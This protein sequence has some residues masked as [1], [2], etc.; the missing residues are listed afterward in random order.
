MPT[1]SSPIACD[2]RPY[3]FHNQ[4][5]TNPSHGQSPRVDLAVKSK[6]EDLVLDGISYGRR[7][8]V[9]AVEAKRLPTIGAGREREYLHGS[10]SKKGSPEQPAQAN[11]GNEKGGL[12]RFKRGKHGPGLKTVGMIGYVQRHSFDHWRK[13]IHQWLDELIAAPVN[14]LK[15][16]ETDRLQEER[17]SERLAWLRSST[18]R[19]TDNQ[20][21]TVRHLWVELG[22]SSAG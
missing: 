10:P 13:T 7:E 5:M 18:W 22:A 4:H 9:L 12:E 3:F 6:S 19:V 17:K 11:A 2:R 1:S 21:V 15:W 14:D 20:L 16:S 8:V